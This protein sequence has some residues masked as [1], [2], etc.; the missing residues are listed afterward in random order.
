MP[1]HVLNAV[2]GQVDH[3][4]QEEYINLIAVIKQLLGPNTVIIA[5]VL[6][7]VLFTPEYSS[8]GYRSLA[9]SIQDKY[10]KLL[11]HH[12]EAHHDWDKA[13]GIYSKLLTS[14]CRMKDYTSK[15]SK[16]LHQC[17]P[18]QVEPL[19]LEVFNIPPISR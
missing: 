18:S 13:F 16:S 8:D 4:V 14:I 2:F 6:C 10:M 12:L 5:L 15:H 7:I 19:L 1:V 11:K 17:D 3:S 9:S